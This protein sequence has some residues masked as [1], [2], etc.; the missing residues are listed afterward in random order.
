MNNNLIR[1]ISKI[2]AAGR[3]IANVEWLNTLT[4]KRCDHLRFD[5][6]PGPDRVYFVD[7]DATA[8]LQ[9]AAT[10]LYNAERKYVI[11]RQANLNTFRYIMENA[12]TI[13]G[14]E[15]N[16]P[17]SRFGKRPKSRRKKLVEVIDLFPSKQFFKHLNITNDKII[18]DLSA[19]WDLEELT[20]QGFKFPKLST[21]YYGKGKG[22]ELVVTGDLDF[23][24]YKNPA[25]DEYLVIV[26]RVA[27]DLLDVHTFREAIEAG[28]FPR[29]NNLQ[30]EQAIIQT[31]AWH[32]RQERERSAAKLE[33][34]KKA[35]KEFKNGADYLELKLPKIN[36]CRWVQLLS[37]QALSREGDVQTHCVANYYQEVVHK[38]TAIL[39]LWDEDN[40]PHLTAQISPS[41]D[42]LSW[43]MR[44]CFGKKN[45]APAERYL[46]SIEML[47]ECR[48]PL[49]LYDH[50]VTH[51]SLTERCWTLSKLDRTKLSID[52]VEG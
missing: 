5:R 10:W 18:A 2:I 24:T 51:I 17:A 49:K 46:D 37:S 13:Y 19:G 6:V 50:Q 7:A 30:Y 29:L 20:N 33:G 22:S 28:V 35:A 3:N 4:R 34:W 1:A 40:G 52:L 9:A 23:S 25:W 48:H 8:E 39:S 16:L 12:K 21:K 38:T 45:S 43:S 26:P 14:F 36:G 31:N 42:G 27:G 32:E 47:V 41:R 11:N 44:Q 15:D